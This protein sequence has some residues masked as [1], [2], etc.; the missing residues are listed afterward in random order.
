MKC[1]YAWCGMGIDGN[2]YQPSALQPSRAQAALA[3]S[4]GSPAQVSCSIADGGRRTEGG[5][6]MHRR[7]L[8][9]V[10]VLQSNA[11]Y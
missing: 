9:V 6:Q 3:Q 1:Q 8:A 2:E 11:T 4:S 10:R 5:A 7:T